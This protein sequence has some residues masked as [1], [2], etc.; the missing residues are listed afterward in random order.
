ME[1]LDN[2]FLD[3]VSSVTELK[4][5]PEILNKSIEKVLARFEQVRKLLSAE[6]AQ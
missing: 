1:L 3:Y 2:S 5:D 4:I 6:S